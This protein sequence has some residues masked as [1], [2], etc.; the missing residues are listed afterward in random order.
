MLRRSIE[1][2]GDKEYEVPF[3]SSAVCYLVSLRLSTPRIN[4]H[5][6][7]RELDEP[8]VHHVPALCKH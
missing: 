6:L 1:S 7:Y 2:I 4:A 8:H 3:S 5:F